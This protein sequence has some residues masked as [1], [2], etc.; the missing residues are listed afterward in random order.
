M[1]DIIGNGNRQRCR[2]LIDRRTAFRVNDRVELFAGK[3]ELNHVEA[4]FE[5]DMTWS[6]QVH[7][8][9]DTLRLGRLVDDRTM[10]E[11]QIA[12]KTWVQ[13][14]RSDECILARR[15][16]SLFRAEYSGLDLGYCDLGFAQSTHDK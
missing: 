3:V 6:P 13:R 5:S 10:V 1:E 7:E 2:Q 8:R 14:D 15:R 4:A 12:V 11:P 9:H 16:I